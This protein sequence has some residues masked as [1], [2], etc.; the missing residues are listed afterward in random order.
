MEF[1]MKNQY[2]RNK[3]INIIHIQ[4][5]SKKMWCHMILLLVIESKLE[6]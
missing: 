1:W 4:K 6:V 3:N 2:V 5:H